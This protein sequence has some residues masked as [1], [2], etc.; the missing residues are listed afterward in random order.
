[1][2]NGHPFARGPRKR[3]AWASIAKASCAVVVSLVV[4]VLFWLPKKQNEK[5]VTTQVTTRVTTGESRSPWTLVD[6]NYAS[7]EI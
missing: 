3:R 4:L 7:S 2:C 1:M 6:W 5:R